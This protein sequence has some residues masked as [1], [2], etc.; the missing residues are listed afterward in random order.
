MVK[1]VIVAYHTSTFLRMPTAL[2][3]KLFPWN[4]VKL[5]QFMMFALL[6]PGQVFG[7]CKHGEKGEVKATPESVA[8]CLVK[9][10]MM[11][12]ANNVA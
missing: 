3:R 4:Q 10:L 6:G 7:N 11:Q 9:R 8:T 2:G 5:I 12:R 1:S